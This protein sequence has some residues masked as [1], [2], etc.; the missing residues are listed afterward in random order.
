MVLVQVLWA[1]PFA[2]LVIVTVMASFDHV[3]LEA[4][5]VLG[6][7]RRRAFLEVELPQIWP[8]L[9]GAAVSMFSQGE[10]D[11]PLA[12]SLF[13][14]VFFGLFFGVFGAVGLGFL[15]SARRTLA[16]GAF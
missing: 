3:Y 1:L 11:L 15:G 7:N 10:V 12:A 5:Y 13:P 8:G 9:M 4:A 16:G 14:I 2:T 6:A